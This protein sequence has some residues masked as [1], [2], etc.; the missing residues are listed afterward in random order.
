MLMLWGVLVG[1]GSVFAGDDE[2]SDPGGD[3]DG[4]TGDGAGG[5]IAEHIQNGRGVPLENLRQ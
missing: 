5:L 4:V 3:A 2:K 1:T